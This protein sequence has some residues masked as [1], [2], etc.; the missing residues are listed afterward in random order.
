[1]IGRRR[2]VGTA[3][4]SGAARYTGR[5]A[6]LA[7]GL[8]VGLSARA[9]AETLADAIAAAYA[10][11]P[12]LVSQRSQLQAT[13]ETYVQALAGFRPVINGSTVATYS[14][15]GSP[16][17]SGGRMTSETNSGSIGLSISQPLY[18]GGRVTAQVQTASAEILAGREQLRN[19]EQSV[20][21][22]AV[23]AYADVTRDRAA[24][25]V[26][27]ASLREV[28]SATDEIR[29]RYEAGA[30]TIVDLTQAQT[31]VEASRAL[32][33][34]A[35]AQL[36]VSVAE[37]VAAVGHSPGTLAPLVTLPG[38]P[39]SVDAAFD[40]AQAENPLVTTAQFNEAQ[41]QAQVRA[42]RAERRPS[43]SLTGSV[44]YSAPLVPFDHRNYDSS[45]ELSATLTQPIYTG[46]VTLSRIRQ[47]TAL[48]SS[49]RTQ[50]EVARRSVVQAVSQAW[51]QRR[52]AASNLISARAETQAAQATFDG[53]R[54]EY[55]AGLR[56]TLDVLIA[57]ETLR[58]ARLE[59]LQAERD[60]AVQAAALLQAVGYLE[61]RRLIVNEPLYD[62]VRHFTQVKGQ[63]AEPLEVV[64]KLLDHIGAPPSTVRLEAPTLSILNPAEIS[65][66]GTQAANPAG[67]K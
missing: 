4:P 14:R 15:Q 3:G 65:T 61:E 54:V 52:A 20:I 7:F 6:T 16:A 2:P 50:V 31:Q 55:R 5:A 56:Q 9:R 26:Q 66:P 64:P 60:D 32:V 49:A 40:I 13:D 18:T 62:P 33:E 23:Q 41:A 44:G 10:T 11:N 42:A 29:A 37:Y 53:M 1:M 35:R 34:S 63:G 17:F 51:S 27:L 43:V 12:N 25:D 46:G 22:A 59:L 47:T 58:S 57:Q 21:F 19:V 36:D 28:A 8:A 67:T 38:A 39:A 24:L 48:A 45:M 30:T